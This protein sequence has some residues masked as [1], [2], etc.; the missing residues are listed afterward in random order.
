LKVGQLK[1]ESGVDSWGVESFERVLEFQVI[2][3]CDLQVPNRRFSEQIVSAGRLQLLGCMKPIS[4]ARKRTLA[5]QQR[6]LEFSTGVNVNCPKRFT[7][8]PSETI[9]RQLVRAADSVSNNLIEAD[10]A[11]STADFV[12]KIRLTLREAKESRTCLEK[13]RMGRLDRLRRS[14]T[15]NARQDSAPSSRRSRSTSQTGS[16]ANGGR[17]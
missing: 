8:I 3:I 1:V 15:W 10:D 7:D 9:W 14:P 13:L 4:D 2:R 17:S 6:A 12:Y 11:S 16:T 5:L